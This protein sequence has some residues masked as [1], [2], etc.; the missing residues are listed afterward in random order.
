MEECAYGEITRFRCKELN[1]TVY[2]DALIKYE[3]VKTM[4]LQ[5]AQVCGPVGFSGE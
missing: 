5:R 3:Y 4:R 1:Y 2:N